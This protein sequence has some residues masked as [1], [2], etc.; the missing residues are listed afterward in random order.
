MK[1]LAYLFAGAAVLGATASTA[2]C[3]SGANTVDSKDGGRLNRKPF[4]AI[5]VN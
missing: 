4:A 3:D 1:S 2:Q 5:F